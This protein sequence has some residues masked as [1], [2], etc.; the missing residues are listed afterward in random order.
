MKRIITTIALLMTLGATL[1]AQL[2]TFEWRLENEQL[3]SST[4]YQFDV[5]IY[6][7]GGTQFEIL[8]G[9]ISFLIDSMW[10]KNGSTV[11]TITVSTTGTSG[12]VTGQQGGSALFTQK[13]ASAQPYFR[14]VISNASAG[15]GTLVP[16]NSM[17]KCF[18]FVLTNTVPFST[19]VPPKFAWR[20]L[21]PS[22]GFNY[23]SGGVSTAVVSNTG[24]AAIANQAFCFTPS[25]WTGSAWNSFSQTATAGSVITTAPTTSQDA[26]I[27][28]G[29]MTQSGTMNCRNLTILSGTTHDLGGANV[30]NVYG[31][32][33][34]NGTLTA[35]TGEVAL[36]GTGSKT[37][38]GSAA[39]FAVNG[40]AFRSAGSYSTSMPIEI[41]N[42]IADISGGGFTLA[43]NGGLLLKSDA[44][45]T[46]LIGQL[47]SGT[48]ITGTITAERYVPANGRRWRFLS[49]PVVGGTTLQWRDNAGSTAGRGINIT[50]TTGTVDFN[51]PNP[52]ALRYNEASAAGGS[53]INAKWEAI[54]GNAVLTNGR[55]Y[56]VFVRGDRTS[57]P[58]TTTNN[59]TTLWVAG[60]YPGNTVNLPVT[61][62]ASLG[63]GWN[64]VGNPYPCPIDW[65]A[66]SGWTKTNV[67][68]TV[69]IWN[70]IT[71]HMVHMMVLHQLTV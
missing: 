54:D 30:L 43:A 22:A 44:N 23:N 24:T 64:L 17:V 57:T 4:T 12:M 52:S 7:T 61:Y 21:T 60:T 46:A 66:A 41:T 70:P 20:F 56:R 67:S 28:T 14:K 65:S 71:N 42:R 59:A 32:I 45:G 69:W 31:N 9:T 15:S 18:T 29:T 26:V 36:Y 62:N 40:I 63:N 38:S 6:N 49:S 33:V 48:S 16:G 10:I 47:S 8:N 50:G 5:N 1:Y 58:S 55:G 3:T 51:V 53:N 68:G 34:Q 27:F 39:K 11:G 25:Y 37:I 19:T 35:T 2:P 13:T